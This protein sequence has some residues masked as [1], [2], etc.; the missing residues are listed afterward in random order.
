MLSDPRTPAP[1]LMYLQHDGHSRTLAGFEVTVC[2]SAA[3]PR[4]SR[5]DAF[6]GAK[7]PRA[8]E[9]FP[10]GDVIS[11][12]VSVSLLLLDPSVPRADLE[13]KLGDG[14][15]QS[16]VKRGLHTMRHAHYEIVWVPHPTDPLSSEVPRI[17]G[18]PKR[19][20]SGLQH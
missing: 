9:P 14:G 3:D 17:G 11:G 10:D 5:L 16:L 20:F 2:A 4:Q 1:Y 18:P 19:L 15:W 8:D 6:A 13:H 12:D 7:R